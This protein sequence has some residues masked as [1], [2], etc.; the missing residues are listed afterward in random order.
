MFEVQ[1]KD[2]CSRL[3]INAESVKVYDNGVNY[4]ALINSDI[5]IKIFQPDLGHQWESDTRVLKHLQGRLSLPIPNFIDSGELS[6]GQRYLAMSKVEG[7]LLIDVW[8]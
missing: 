7:E 1:L 3:S 5:V 4:C 6:N 2:V 8:G